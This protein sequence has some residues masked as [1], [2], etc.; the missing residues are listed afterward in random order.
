MNTAVRR[1]L[2]ATAL[3]GTALLGSA[4]AAIAAP[5][6]APDPGGVVIVDE[7]DTGDLN[8]IWT[9]APLGVPV[10]G[11]LD[12]LADVPGKLLPLP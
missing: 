5:Q 1:G 7:P 6:A 10:L 3:A 12:S 8:N 4:T 9:F 11:L 2:A